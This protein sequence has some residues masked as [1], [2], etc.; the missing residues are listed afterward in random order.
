MTF[1]FRRGLRDAKKGRRSITGVASAAFLV[2]LMHGSKQLLLTMMP[3]SVTTP[4]SIE[5]VQQ[6]GGQPELGAVFTVL[7]GLLG[8][9]V[10]PTL[11]RKVGVRDPVAIG[12]AM[13]TSSHGI[14]SARVLRDSELQGGASGLA[15]A[16]AGIAT[17]IIIAIVQYWL[18]VS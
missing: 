7:A 17:S 8:S 13:G 9:V 1:G 5:L 10:G 11:L 15:M 3:K 4:I 14:G 16:M 2:L 18:R 6:L 12:L